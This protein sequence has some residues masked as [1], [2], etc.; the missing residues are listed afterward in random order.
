MAGG[1]SALGVREGDAIAFILRNDFVFFEAAMGSAIIG[2]Y[3]VPINWHFKSK[4]VAYILDDCAAKL[5]IILADLLPEIE[6][7]IPPQ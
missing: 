2:A 6:V 4:E 3:A 1:F 5:L 7:A